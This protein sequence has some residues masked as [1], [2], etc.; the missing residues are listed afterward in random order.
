MTTHNG[1]VIRIEQTICLGGIEHDPAMLAEAREEDRWAAE[2]TGIN[3]RER[4]G[5]RLA[6]IEQVLQDTTEASLLS[7]LREEQA[8]LATRAAELGE[9]IHCDDC[10][11]SIL[12]TPGRQLPRGWR[13]SVLPT[14]QPAPKTLHLWCPKHAEHASGSFCDHL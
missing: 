10:Y 3:L 8:R 14:S 9:V 5:T 11:A 7:A 12:W 6:E 4:I 1:L 2:Q 13:A